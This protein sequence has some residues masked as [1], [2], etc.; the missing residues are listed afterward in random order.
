[1]REDFGAAYI[2]RIDLCVVC[3]ILIH[4]LDLRE[5]YSGRNS[6]PRTDPAYDR[7]Y[8]RRLLRSAHQIWIRCV[9]RLLGLPFAAVAAKA[10]DGDERC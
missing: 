3:I 8:R 4:L 9:V 6:P 10:L 7:Q 1:M 2:R 5:C